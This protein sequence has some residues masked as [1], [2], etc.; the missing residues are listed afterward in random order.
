MGGFT[1]YRGEISQGVLSAKKMAEFLEAGKINFPTVSKKEIEDRSKGDGLSKSLAV[2]Q[3]AW[4]VV[5]C[6]ARRGQQLDI[7]GLELLTCA[8][9][10]LNGVMYF[11]LWNKPLHVRCSVPVYLLDEDKPKKFERRKTGTNS[12][13]SFFRPLRLSHMD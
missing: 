2:W 5:Q 12:L 6:I 10:V 7:T 11:F 3:T 8:L 4:F 9:A 1:L 13:S